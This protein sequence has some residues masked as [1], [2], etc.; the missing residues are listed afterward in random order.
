MLHGIK[1]HTM[2]A[3]ERL[4]IERG[5]EMLDKLAQMTQRRPAVVML[6]AGRGMR[7]H[8]DGHKLEQRVELTATDTILARSVRHALDTHFRV[9]LVT[10]PTDTG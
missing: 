7:F 4:S 6:A 8:G 2:R 9:V 5:Q 3:R 10:T 1:M